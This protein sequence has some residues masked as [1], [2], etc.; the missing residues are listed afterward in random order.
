MELTIEPLSL[1]ENLVHT[2]DGIVFL[3]F[4]DF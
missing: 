2:V 1:L 4:D 3:L